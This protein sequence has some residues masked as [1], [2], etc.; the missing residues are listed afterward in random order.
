MISILITTH[1]KLCKGMLDSLSMI[2]GENPNISVLEFCDDYNEYKDK[3]I[4]KLD[5]L[6]LTY[7]GVMI[8]TDIMG[9]TPFN[10]SYKYTMENNKGNI[11]IIT[12]VNLPM[13]IETSLAL[14]Q[15]NE[16]TKLVNIAIEAGKQSINCIP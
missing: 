7:S 16:L 14:S 3:L 8:F 13:V 10:E 6:L 11:K 9:G 2:A 5:E 1:G 15:E 12:G 4:E